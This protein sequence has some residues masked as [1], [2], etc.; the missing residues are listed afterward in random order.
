[1]SRLQNTRSGSA[2]VEDRGCRSMPLI[3]KVESMKGGR[4][5][6]VVEIGDRGNL[7]ESAAIARRDDRVIVPGRRVVLLSKYQV[8]RGPL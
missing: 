3:R 7:S 4:G 5:Q 2:R 6:K 1:M 8:G